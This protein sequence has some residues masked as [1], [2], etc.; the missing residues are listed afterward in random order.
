MEMSVGVYWAVCLDVGNEYAGTV[1]GM[2]NS[3]GN[4]GSALLPVAFGMIVQHTGSWV[5]PFIVASVLLVIA[6]L[7]WTRIN[8]EKSLVDELELNAE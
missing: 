1:S 5:Y 7:L 3:I 8:P 4:L 2:M 6:S